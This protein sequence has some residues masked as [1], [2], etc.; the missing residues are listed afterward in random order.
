VLSAVGIIS[1]N[2]RILQH[3]RQA[4][5]LSKRR[6]V[7]GVKARSNFDTLTAARQQAKAER[8]EE[9]VQFYATSPD[10]GATEAAQAVGISRQSVYNYTREL[11]ATGRIERNGHGV[12]VRG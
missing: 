3:R 1:L 7:K 12:T 4:A 5:K 11:E 9:L 10:A 6:S 2:E 8:L